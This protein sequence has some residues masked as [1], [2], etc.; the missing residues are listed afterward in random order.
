MTGA[1]LGSLESIHF[2]G[3]QMRP[4]ELTWTHLQPL[5][6]TPIH[7]NSLELNWTHLGSLRPVGF[8]Q[9]RGAGE[10]GTGEGGQLAG[11]LTGW[12]TYWLTGW[13]ACWLAGWL[14]CWMAGLRGRLSSIQACK[15]TNRRT[16]RRGMKKCKQL[17][18][19]TKW[20]PC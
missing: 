14:A 20:C 18:L 8:R 5:G 16:S 13:L 19:G 4:L 1:H 15:N 6:L 2:I 17:D 12:P 9:K 10:K 7:W 11:L 3:T